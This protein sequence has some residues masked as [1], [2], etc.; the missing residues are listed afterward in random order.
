[1]K[2]FTKLLLLICVVFYSSQMS[3]AQSLAAGAYTCTGAGSQTLSVVTTT[4]ITA[5]SWRNASN[6]V[7]GTTVSVVVP[8]GTYTVIYTKGGVNTTLGP[9][10][11]VAGIVPTAPTVTP[12]TVSS[13]VCG[14]ATQTLTSSTAANYAWL[15]DGVAIASAVNSTL[16]LAGNSVAVPSTNNYAVSVSNP[17]TG[18]TAVSNQVSVTL[19]PKPATPSIS[20]TSPNLICG[21]D[22]KTLT[23]TSGGTAYIWKRGTTTLASTTNTYTATGNE[24]PANTYN[25]TVSYA[26]S[27]GCRSDDSAPASLVL[28]PKPATPVISPATLTTPIC[29]TATQVLTVASGATSYSWKRDGS[30]IT[31]STNSITVTGT[32]V[33]VGGTY[34]YTVSSVNAVGCNSDE[35]TAVSLK[36]SPKPAT[37]TITPAVF[38]PNIVCGTETK[39]LTATSGGAKYNWFRNTVLVTSSTS[40]NTLTVSGADVITGGTYTFT[41]SLENSVGCVSDVSTSGVVLQLFPAV[42]ARPTVSN[43]GGL[44]FCEG[45]SVTLTSSYTGNV[46]IWS[47]NG[48]DT[49]TATTTGIVVRTSNTVTV[50]ARDAN[51]CTSVSSLPVVVTVNLKPTPP[52]I[53]LSGARGICEL[54]SI[55]LTSDNKGSG[56]YLWSNG[57]TTR[58][59]TVRDGG[60]YTLTYTDT[61]TP[62]C[63]SL[64][65]QSSV[66][67]IN[68]LPVRPTIANLR[69]TEFCFRDFTTLRAS[70]T[71]TGTTFEW[72]YNNQTGS[73]IDIAGSA[74]LTTVE[75][76]RVSAKSVAVFANNPKACKSRV[77]SDVVTITVNPLPVTPDITA[78]RALTFCPDSTVTLTSSVSP[79]GAYKWINAKDNSEFSTSRTVVIDTTSKFFN[80]ALIEKVGRFYVRTVSDK[81]CVSDTSRNVI[82]TVRNAPQPAS[83]AADPRSATVCLGGKV[84]LSALV[85]NTNITRYSWRDESNQQELSTQPEVSVITS[86]D[87]SVRVRDVFGCFAAY[88]KPIKVSINSLPNKPTLTLTKPKVF[89]EEDS[90]VVQASLASTTPNGN[91]TLYSWIVD[92]QTVLETFSRTFSYKRVGVISV[93]LTD[94]N[95]CKAAAVSDT[96]RTTVNPLPNS[97]TITVRG[98]NPFCADKNVALNAVGAA[99]VTYRWSTGATTQTITTNTAGNVTVQAIN[100][101]G[102]LSKPSQPVLIRVNPLPA[103]PRLTANGDVTFCEGSRVRIVSSSAF[104][105]Y[106]FRNNT[107]SLGL[108]DDNTSIFASRTGSYSAKVQDDNGCISLASASIAVDSRP[109][110]TPTIIKQVGSFT[111]DAQGLGDE[112]GYLWRYNGDLQRDLTTKLIKAKKDG[113]YQVQASITYTGVNITGGRLICY[114]KVSDAI[115]YVQDI[116]FEGVSIFPNPSVDGVINIEAAEDL[117]GTEIMIYDLYGRIVANYTID[118]FNTLKRVEL[119]KLHGTTYIVKISSGGLEKTRKVLIF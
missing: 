83:I 118:K 76:I 3:K 32:D 77:A 14:T 6:A 80:T 98:A 41:A 50:R 31:G 26:N 95:G 53:D 115:K 97:P 73:Q 100:G 59:I 2:N 96:I 104:K 93:A 81:S 60:T 112:N 114:S 108:G 103:A 63:T 119:P 44:T 21:S 72:D 113:D 33:A 54:D 30:G 34:A 28:S 12:A 42:P 71:T 92:G 36:V 86:G 1:M 91:R 35:S 46:N 87:Y 55:I 101:F 51:G 13:P 64:P 84:T 102:C 105:A 52:V 107:D 110:P 117:I 24:A 61:Q 23:A 78:S 37:P 75:T 57:R 62:A 39:T 18:C 90:V 99:G 79:T 88:S 25:Y 4:G 10:T 94:S 40:S 68:P 5:Y 7:V 70:S 85:S 111:L 49:T 27:A 66:V 56:S 89:C 116:S 106:W 22:T 16:S 109:N 17:T 15:R 9:V 48:V 45:G 74:K 43:S 11:V 38:T 67:T 69:P 19:A 47:R 20:F 82:V 8:S 29:G 65:S 58:S